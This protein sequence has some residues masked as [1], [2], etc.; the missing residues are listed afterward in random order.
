VTVHFQQLTPQPSFLI[1]GFLPQP[2]RALEAS[3]L[4]TCPH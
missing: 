3:L 4:Q 2:T 1:G